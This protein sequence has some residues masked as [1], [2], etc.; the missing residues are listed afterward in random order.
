MPTQYRGAPHNLGPLPV[1]EPC[2]RH[3]W[4]EGGDK[5]R[6]PS[7]IFLVRM[8]PPTP[9]ANPTTL[10][11]DQKDLPLNATSQRPSKERFRLAMTYW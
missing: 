8:M 3:H 9:T 2:T 1:H 10:L 4:G 7:N 5:W 11:R 6:A